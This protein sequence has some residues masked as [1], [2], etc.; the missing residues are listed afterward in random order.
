M[1]PA[2]SKLL[3]SNRNKDSQKSFY[4]DVILLHNCIQNGYIEHCEVDI[5]IYFGY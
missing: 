3:R 2:R 1:K 5:T 4:T